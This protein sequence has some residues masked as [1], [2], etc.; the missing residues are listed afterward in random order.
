VPKDEK[1]IIGNFAV[2]SH[3]APNENILAGPSFLRITPELD[4]IAKENLYPQ[5]LS[6]AKHFCKQYLIIPKKYL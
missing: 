6:R 2:R 3:H 5:D 1:G 4:I